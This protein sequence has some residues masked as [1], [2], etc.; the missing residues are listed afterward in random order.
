MRRI[1]FLVLAL[2]AISGCSDGSIGSSCSSAAVEN[3]CVEGAVCA[4]DRSESAEPP[5]D[6][7]ADTFHCREVCEIEADCTQEGFEC[8][9][10]SGSMVSACQPDDDSTADAASPGA[11]AGP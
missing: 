1:L 4:P 7:N 2:A 6:P 9:R 8:R 11:D 10:V 5:E 3:A